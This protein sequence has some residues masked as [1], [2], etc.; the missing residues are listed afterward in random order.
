MGHSG[1][2]RIGRIVLV[3]ATESRPGPEGSLPSHRTAGMPSVE[4]WR[5]LLRVIS[6]K[7]APVGKSIASSKN[8]LHGRNAQCHAAAGSAPK[9]EKSPCHR[10]TVASRALD[11]SA[12]SNR[13][14]HSRVRRR[15]RL[16]VHG[17]DGTRGASAHNLVE[18]GNST[19]SARLRLSP[20]MAASLAALPTPPR[21]RHATP[22]LARWTSL[23]H[24]VIGHL[25]PRAPR[26]AGER[27]RGRGC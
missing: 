11:H 18:E 27:S 25:G 24:S 21:C 9:P 19:A 1:S 22:S 12:S 26:I 23:V 3:H 6:A 17:D 2:G 13:A 5:R 16:T 7:L 10:R 14:T 4:L 15:L 8:G 20:S